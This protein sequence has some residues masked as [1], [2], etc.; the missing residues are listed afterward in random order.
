M[1]KR[2][3]TRHVFPRRSEGIRRARKFKDSRAQDVA[4]DLGSPSINRIGP[5]PN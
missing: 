5:R 4:V 2:S 3:H 1:R